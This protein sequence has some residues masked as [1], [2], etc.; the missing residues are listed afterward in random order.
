MT[1]SRAQLSGLAVDQAHEQNN[2]KVKALGGGLKLLNRDDDGDALLKWSVSGPEVSNLVEDYEVLTGLLQPGLVGEMDH[3]ESYEAFQI[4]F[5]SDVNKL[6]SCINNSFNPFCDSSPLSMTY[7]N[8]GETVGSHKEL[9]KSLRTLEKRGQLLYETFVSERLI[10]CER[11]LSDPIKRNNFVVPS[12]CTKM[13]L[14]KI[15]TLTAQQ[16]KKLLLELK[17]VYRYRK[18]LVL[19]ALKTEPGDVP[20]V[21]TFDNKLYQAPKSQLSKRLKTLNIKPNAV[22]ADIEQ[23][24]DT[25]HQLVVDLSMITVLTIR[26][27]NTNRVNTF[28]KLFDEI[29]TAIHNLGSFQRLDIVSDNYTDS[30]LLKGQTRSGRGRGTTVKFKLSDKVPSNLK[31]DFLLSTE[32][33]RALYDMM[34]DYFTESKVGQYVFKVST[35]Y[36]ITK[37]KEVLVGSMPSSSHIEADYRIVTHII[38]GARNGMKSAL[39]RANDTDITVLLLAYLPTILEIC[40]T[41]VLKF[42]SGTSINR[43]VFNMNYMMHN[44]GPNRCRALL[45]LHSFTGSDY[46]PSFY[47]IGKLSWYDL[48]LK[49]TKYDDTLIRLSRY[50]P[51]LTQDDFQKV[52]EFTLEAYK[53]DQKANM[54]V[55]RF[56]ALESPTVNTFRKLPPSCR[57]LYMHTLRSTYVSGHLWGRA[58]ELEP[59]LPPFYEW[60]WKVVQSYLYYTR[61]SGVP[62]F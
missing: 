25:S 46:T 30:H 10:R 36:V 14:Y 26:V 21:F 37:A 57:A 44:L 51:S 12:G 13:G 40:P 28:M 19:E 41:F 35:K 43:L 34:A 39:V 8:N 3:H 42:D 59:R 45:F 29:W 23:A 62:D 60:G 32:N 4:R 27:I 50:L 38:D 49:N 2:A 48:F 55:S 56:E 18:S 16:D 7:L 1:L 9:T 53:I 22:D 54:T 31:T 61:Q 17:S 11:P 6:F 52:T 5:L 47:G 33:K 24:V 20:P 15:T 58:N